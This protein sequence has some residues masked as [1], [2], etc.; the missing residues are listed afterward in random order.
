MVV[1][2]IITFSVLIY[3]VL[4]YISFVTDHYFQIY[5]TPSDKQQNGGF[6]K[7]PIHLFFWPAFWLVFLLAKVLKLYKQ[8]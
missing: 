5:I 1:L 7:I 4:G 3:C 6:S 2:L 8:R